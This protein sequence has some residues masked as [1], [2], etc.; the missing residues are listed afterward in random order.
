MKISNEFYQRGL[1]MTDFLRIFGTRSTKTLKKNWQFF[2]S[3]N[4]FPSMPS[5][6]TG[7][8]KQFQNIQIVFNNNTR[9]LVLKFNWSED[10]FWLFINC[11]AAWQCPFNG[12]STRTE[13]LQLQYTV[14]AKLP[15][16][17]IQFVRLLARQCNLLCRTFFLHFFFARFI[18]QSRSLLWFFLFFSHPPSHHFPNGPF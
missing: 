9:S 13:K 12:N 15:L 5:V 6:A 1:T 18:F 16:R 17:R 10:T 11:Q 7:D 2:S 14:A 8:R 4:P 3:F